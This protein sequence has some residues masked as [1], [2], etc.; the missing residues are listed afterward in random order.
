M[1]NTAADG[2]Q[3]QIRAPLFSSGII[4]CPENFSIAN[5]NA[6]LNTYLNTATFSISNK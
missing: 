6:Y 1:L 2:R 4:F 5:S 3:E